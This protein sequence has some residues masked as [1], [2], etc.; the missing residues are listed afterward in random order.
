[1]NRS[2]AADAL[3]RPLLESTARAITERWFRRLQ[4]RDG[5]S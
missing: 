2:D 1:M 4:P 5:F 3:L